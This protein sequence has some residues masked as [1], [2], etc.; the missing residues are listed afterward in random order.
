MLNQS[1][2]VARVGGWELEV[3]TGHLFWTEETYRIHDT[4][5][6]EF[7]PSVDAGVSYFLPDYR[8]TISRALEDAIE[9][10]I[11]YDI[12]LE[13]YT[14]KGRKIDVRTTCIVTQENGK[15][16]RLT[17]IFQDISEQ[18]AIQRT[19]EQ[20]NSDLAIANSAIKHSAHYD[21]LTGLPNRYLLADRMDQA[22]VKSIRNQSF[23]AIA[24]INVDGFKAINDS[25]RHDMGDELLKALSEQLKNVLR[26]GDTLARIGGDEFVAI[27]DELASP[28]ESDR[29]LSRLLDSARTPMVV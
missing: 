14:T 16:V 4:C 23:L 12:E 1:Q 15:I 6:E 18:K 13:T 20:I 24:F 21:S 26:D 5:P 3:N 22:I 28:D 8:E 27:I 7:N 9:R 17:G 11:G 25:H 29:I 19:L 2:Q 10:G